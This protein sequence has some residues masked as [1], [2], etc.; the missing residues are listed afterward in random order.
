MAQ[1]DLDANAVSEKI[2][3]RLS[4]SQYEVVQLETLVELLQARVDELEAK[5]AELEDE[6]ASKADVPD[7]KAVSNGHSQRRLPSEDK[8]G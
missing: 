7:A 5:V 6:A 2:L 1:Y 3:V 4:R 8:R